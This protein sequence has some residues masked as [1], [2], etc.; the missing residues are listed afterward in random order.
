[1]PPQLRRNS[2]GSGMSE[3]LFK[4]LD[5]AAREKNTLRGFLDIEV[6]DGMLIRGISLHARN[7]ARWLGMPSRQF[8]KDGTT[9]YAPVIEFTDRAAA[10]RFR[11]AVLAALDRYQHGGGA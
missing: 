10:D 4:I 7:G 1:M 9:G 6:T 8:E 5:F 2:P 11:D 3:T